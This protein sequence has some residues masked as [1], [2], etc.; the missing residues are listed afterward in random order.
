MSIIPGV[1]MIWNVSPRIIVFP[2]A[3]EDATIEDIQDTLLDIEADPAGMPYLKL[4][5]T[6][7]GE[8]LGGGTTVGWTMEL[9]DAQ[10]HFIGRTTALDYGTGRTCDQTDTTGRTLYVDD[11][12]F[13]TAGV[14]RG[15]T[16]FN[17]S[18]AEMATPLRRRLILMA[19]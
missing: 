10:I 19:R 17:A 16:V 3:I 1:E 13:V 14:E 6:S 7:G 11:A 12:D 2:I 8:S 4:R 15:C 9:Q 5:N 18:T